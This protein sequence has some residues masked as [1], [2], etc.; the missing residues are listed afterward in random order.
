MAVLRL[1][2]SDEISRVQGANPLQRTV[3]DD[4]QP[5]GPV[6]KII[7][8]EPPFDTYDR[9]KDYEVVWAEF[10]RRFQKI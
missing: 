10:E 4:T 3:T 5:G 8:Y 2:L 9:E 1:G 7:E 6:Q